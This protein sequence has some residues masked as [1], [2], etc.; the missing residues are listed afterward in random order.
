MPKMETAVA[1][2]VA[3]A[4]R[5]G[6]SLIDPGEYTA[7]LKGVKVS[8]K[9]DRN[10]N[11]YWIWSFEL[12]DDGVKGTRLSTNTHFAA[13]GSQDWWI[14]TVYDGFEAKMNVDT[15]TLVGRQVTLV[16]DQGE[17]TGGPRKGQIRNEITGVLPLK[18]KADD[19]DEDFE[20][21]DDEDE[22]DF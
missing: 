20:S 2:R 8:P 3:K 5:G 11:T 10:Q 16:V 19:G 6:Q 15:D 1:R 7:T 9:K 22:P 18:S 12:D 14:A 13:D 21:E 17:I 4:D